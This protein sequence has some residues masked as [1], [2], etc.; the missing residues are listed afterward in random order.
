MIRV[1]QRRAYDLRDEEYLRL[2]ILLSCNPW[3]HCNRQTV[4]NR[5]TTDFTDFTDKEG[6]A[7]DWVFTRAVAT[8][9]LE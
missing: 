2:N 6:I 7:L 3:F 8:K 5:K 9:A 1:L 4:R